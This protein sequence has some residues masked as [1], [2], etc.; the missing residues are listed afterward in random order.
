VN[1]D[2]VLYIMPF[3]SGADIAQLRARLAPNGEGS[4]VRLGFARYAFLQ[5]MD[6][7]VDIAN[8]AAV[9]AAIA[10]SIAQIGAQVATA[11][12][13]GYPV[14]LVTMAGVKD[15]YD[16]VQTASEKEDIRS[17]Q[18][19][20]DNVLARG[21]WSYSRYARKKHVIQQAYMREVAK[22]IARQMRNN[23]DTLIAASGDAEVE[24]ARPTQAAP[25]DQIYADFSPFT[26]AEFRDWIRL[27]GLYAPGGELAGQGFA[28]G[29]RYAGDATPGADTNGDGHTLN[30]DFNTSFTTWNLKHFDWSLDDPYMSNDPHAISLATYQ[31]PGF[32]KTPSQIPAGF[33]PPRAPGNAG[34]NPYWNLWVTFKQSL[35][36]RYNVEFARWMTTSPAAADGAAAADAGYT[37]PPERWYSYQ[38]PADLMFQCPN[39]CSSPNERWYSSMSSWWTADIT[40]YGSMGVTAYNADWI[41]PGVR[42]IARTLLYVAPKIAERNRRWSILEW[43]PGVLKRDTGV[44]S[45]L[46]LFRSEM[47]LVEKYRPNLVQPFMWG[48]PHSEVMGTPFETALRELIT[49][50]KDGRTPKLVIDPLP[51]GTKATQPLTLTGWAADFNKSP[52][53]GSGIDQVNIYR[54]PTNGA[55]P[56]LVGSTTYGIARPDVATSYGAQFG[57]AGFSL[58]IP[59]LPPG[60]YQFEARAHST[61][62][63]SFNVTA[64]KTVELVLLLGPASGGPTGG[65]SNGATFRYD[66]VDYPTVGGRVCFPDCTSYMVLGSGLL[67]PG[68][69]TPNCPPGSGA[70]QTELC[71]GVVL[72]GEGA[73]GVRWRVSL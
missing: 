10:S 32:N 3:S 58:T 1:R 57:N 45:D 53:G 31:S 52:G 29:A 4:Y 51:N 22:E 60:T 34:D 50:I 68:R 62:T 63:Q 19:Y 23:P 38:I 12:S 20:A 70:T 64:T 21:W 67:I 66:G 36:H 37:I 6:W 7:N 39:G 16:P 73:D 59:T 40:P 71:P 69:A 35:I 46:E 28:S 48:L 15:T 25:A 2:D 27:G 56:V 8:P 11:R 47:A 72:F 26:V 18:W 17:M 41:D 42:M 49:R 54:I 13:G 55:P 9:K 14:S 43:H 65:T 44:S 5:M 30:G 24:L 61:V 33:D